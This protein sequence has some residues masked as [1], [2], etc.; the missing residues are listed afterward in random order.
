M[1]RLILFLVLLLSLPLTLA[2]CNR[3]D[4][5]DYVSDERSD[6]FCAETETFSILISCV[7]RERPFLTDGVVSAKSKSVEA[8]LTEKEPSGKEYEI[9]FLED[10]PRGGEMSFRSVSGDY[11]YSRGVEEFPSGSISLRVICGEERVELMATSVKTEKTLSAREA[12]EFAV[13]A[14]KETVSR[15]SAGEF[16]GEFHVRLLRRD[17]NYYYVGI[18]D[19]QGGTLSLLLDSETGAVLARRE[20]R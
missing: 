15:M 19:T 8:V 14:E 2:G 9:Y 7:F 18:V 11:A 5:Y 16:C 17:K 4:Y 1:K 20:K 12:L 10:V 3:I 6:L 13:E